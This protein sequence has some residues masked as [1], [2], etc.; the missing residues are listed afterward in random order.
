[1]TSRQACEDAVILK[2]E[3]WA[4]EHYPECFCAPLMKENAEA[5]RIYLICQ[6]QMIRAGMEGVAVDINHV[7]V[8]EAID[9]Y[10]VRDGVDCFEKV[11]VLNRHF[12]EH[13]REQA[14]E[15]KPEDLQT[16]LRPTE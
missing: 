6:G 10:Q 12:M 8:W 7:A 13:N 4:R 9:R 5:L 1:M 15:M 16:L 14:A 11:L 3:K 2:G